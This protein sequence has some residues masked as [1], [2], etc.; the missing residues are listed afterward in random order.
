VTRSFKLRE[1]GISLVFLL[2]ACELLFVA[3]QYWLLER[4]EEESRRQDLT[5]QIISRASALMQSLYNAGDNCGRYAFNRDLECLRKYEAAKN[6]IQ[7]ELA[8]LDES[9]KDS[10]EQ[11]ALLK[12]IEANIHD[13]LAIL[14]E[15]K[16]VS[17]TEAQM[18]AMSYAIKFR[19]KV[20][21]R[22]ES[23]IADIMQFLAT[24][25]KIENTSPAIIKMQ[26]DRIKYLLIAGL[27]LNIVAAFVLGRFFVGNIT[28]R[29]LIVSENAERLRARDNLHAPLLGSD[30]IAQLDQT[31][32]E[33]SHS[34]RGEE[35]LLVS[36]QEQLRALIEQMPVGI[37]LFNEESLQITFANATLQK[38]LACSADALQGS[39][40]DAY[41]AAPDGTPV[42]LK[43]MEA[44]TI[45]ELVGR[46]RD[47][48]EFPAEFTVSGADLARWGERLAIIV[49]I[50][51]RREIEKMREAFVAMVSHELRTP[52][53]SIA[54]FLQLLP[55][56]VYGQVD[57]R[58]RAPIGLAE[59]DVDHLI[60]LINDLLDLEKL[61]A[62]K[63]DLAASKI[64]LEDVIDAAVEACSRPADEALVSL[65]FEG[66]SVKLQADG[67]QLLRAI[68]KVT[69]S[70]IRLA[71]TGSTLTL[72]AL[73]GAAAPVK[74]LFSCDNITLP[75]RAIENIFEP[76]QEIE[77]PAGPVSPG[78]GLALAREIVR[79]HGGETGADYAGA[80]NPGNAPG[81]LSLWL[82][83]PAA[84]IAAARPKG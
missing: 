14:A 63:L 46:K 21:T 43:R 78:L 11:L 40:I 61:R 9:V 24:E 23:L 25:R 65:L 74:I 62:G 67:E 55:M 66:C 41:L 13:N 75:V 81:K 52:L 28:R 42:N 35:E 50:S 53:T 32:R 36:S 5:K 51:Q 48:T 26:S 34:L 17:D 38:I 15:M 54:G 60:M 3:G 33:M 73:G 2:L 7:S 80:D 18:V 20:Q 1:K 8:W 22:M 31:F 12:K 6:T 19:A 16:R 45:I 82:E 84:P 44:E 59:K 69:E 57:Q 56:G 4:A 37:V 47:G 58:A 30:E 79:Q 64:D 27:V 29:L 77:S 10:P 72:S 76:F 70:L 39:R 68:T 49:D 83:L 71:P